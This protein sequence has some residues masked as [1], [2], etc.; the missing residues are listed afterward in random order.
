V[1]CADLCPLSAQLKA[2]V[3]RCTREDGTIGLASVC[4][5]CHHQAGRKRHWSSPKQL[6]RAI[7]RNR[8]LDS[9]AKVARGECE[10]DD[11]SCHR[12]VT[13]ENVGEFE[14]D[15]FVQSFDDPGYRGVGVLVSI[16]ASAARCDRERANCRLLYIKCH[17]AHS[18]KQRRERMAQLRVQQY[19]TC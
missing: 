6:L 3:S 12:P 18:G 1:R 13:A 16:G 15:H 11:E 10:C 17:Q 4:G 8:A 5:V 7:A 2:E 19:I 9:A 14:W